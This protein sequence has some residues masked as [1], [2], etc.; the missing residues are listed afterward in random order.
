MG[1]RSKLY[2]G[3]FAHSHLTQWVTI[4]G[5]F[6]VCSVSG[7][8]I[9]GGSADKIA[10]MPYIVSLN[11]PKLKDYNGF[12]CGGTLIAPK[13]V[14]TAAHCAK[15]VEAHEMFVRAGSRYSHRGGQVRNVTRSIVHELYGLETRKD[16]DF[17]L[18]ELNSPFI[19]GNTVQTVDLSDHRD[20]YAPGELCVASGW[21][22]TEK[23][24]RAMKRLRSV[25]VPLV[26]HDR[27]KAAYARYDSV[28]SNQMLC[29]GASGIDSCTGDSG[30]PLVC[31]NKLVGVISWGRGCG[32]KTVYGVYGNV[33]LARVWI[34][35]N[36]DV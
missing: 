28:I 2:N 4:F 20:K 5:V 23:S 24:K 6:L 31:R 15:H 21:G 10:N 14:L 13:W 3:S 9:Y 8:M 18:L 36:S 11:A 27:C 34:L 32:K 30:G 1:K 29:A 33:S 22:R 26:S 19:G 16:R 35:F 17:A 12:F 25:M 7:S